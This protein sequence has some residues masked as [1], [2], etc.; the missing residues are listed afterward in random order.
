MFG[1]FTKK[2]KRAAIKLNKLEHAP[3]AKAIVAA[4]ILVA[5]ADDD[6]SDDEL[7]SLR[8]VIANNE[9]LAPFVPETNDWISEYIDLIQGSKRTGKLEVMRVVEAVRTDRK[10]AEN[11]MAAVLDIA[12]ANGDISKEEM[13]VLEQI[14]STLGINLKSML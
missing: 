5:N 3:L 10:A 6:I 12:E 11:V 8:N 13:A 9:T 14:A 7:Q 1:I 4:G 2:A